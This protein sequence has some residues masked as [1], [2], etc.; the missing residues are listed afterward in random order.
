MTLDGLR[1]KAARVLRVDYERLTATVVGPCHFRLL[2]P[3]ETTM[4]AVST[5]AQKL[6]DSVPVW[7]LVDVDREERQ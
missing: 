1:A 4:E 6:N 5:V 2:V 3:A 7:A